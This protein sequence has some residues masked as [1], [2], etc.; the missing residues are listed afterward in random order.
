MKKGM[1]SNTRHTTSALVE[2]G[3]VAWA[4]V[5]EDGMLTQEQRA[6]MSAM[7]LAHWRGWQGSGVSVAEYARRIL[8]ANSYGPS[9]ERLSV[10][11]AQAELFNETM[12]RCYG[13][14]ILRSSRR[15]DE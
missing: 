3:P 14:R 13:F 4:Q 5:K 1:S 11:A 15:D 10:A 8:K 12:D 9:R 7:W 2:V 6:T